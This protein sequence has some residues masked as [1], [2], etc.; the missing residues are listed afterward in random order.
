MVEMIFYIWYR[1]IFELLD[2]AA[3]GD[4]ALDQF[5]FESMQPSMNA[6]MGKDNHKGLSTSVPVVTKTKIKEGSSKITKENETKRTKKSS[7]S[8]PSGGGFGAPPK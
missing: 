6:F 3:L 4:E 2:Y 1:F 8:K 5:E 7:S